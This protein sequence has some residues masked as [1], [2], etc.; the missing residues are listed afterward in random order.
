ME[1][2]NPPDGIYYVAPTAFIRRNIEVVDSIGRQHECLVKIEGQEE[3]YVWDDYDNGYNTGNIFDE[4]AYYID[5]YSLDPHDI[6]M[7]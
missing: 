3:N 5:A 6:D 2:E 7:C 1:I 4:R